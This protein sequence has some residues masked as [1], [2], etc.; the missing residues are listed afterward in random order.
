M[1]A[2]LADAV[3][4]EKQRFNVYTMMLIISFIA[5]LIAC[6]V[7]WT[8]MGAYMYADGQPTPWPP[9]NASAAKV[10]PPPAN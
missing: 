10:T 7:L 1:Q 8:E 4:T 9:W 3:P 6:V 5:T 2:R